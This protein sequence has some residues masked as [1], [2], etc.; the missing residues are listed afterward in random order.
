ML[1]VDGVAAVNVA[2]GRGRL[3]EIELDPTR[4]EAFGLSVAA[5]RSRLASLEYISEA[6]IVEE[7]GLRQSLAIRYRLESVEELRRTPI[8]AQGGRVVRLGD[9]AILRDSFQEPTSHYRIDGRPAIEVTIT[10]EHGTNAVAVADR[11]TARMAELAAVQ[12]PGVRL[13]LDSN[14][15]DEIKAELSDMRTRAL[16]SALI[17]FAV[18]LVFLRSFRSA[19]LVFSAIGFCVLITINGIYWSGMSI[20]VFTLMGIALGFGLIVDNAI[21]VLEN[22]YRYRGRGELAEV[23]AERGTRAVV[24][25]VLASTLTT[26][27]VI[28]PFV[29]LQGE[30]PRT[31][32]RTGSFILS[33]RG[34]RD[35]FWT[36][37]NET[38]KCRC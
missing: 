2:G 16:F 17:I 7:D 10:R 30:A 13:I 38:S 19:G 12:A 6:G 36:S 23:A 31:P 18:L 20:N 8:V 4:V 22:V 21:V 33:P 35:R 3:L 24:L 15:S 25:P 14:Q 9:I 28:V 37:G 34:G 29:Y 32:K 26:L 1:R 11:A 5:V 27:I